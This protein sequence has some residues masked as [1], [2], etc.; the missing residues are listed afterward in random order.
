MVI[1]WHFLLCKHQLWVLCLLLKERE[2]VVG[3]VL[4]WSYNSL[5]LLCHR[6]PRPTGDTNFVGCSMP[7]PHRRRQSLLA[8]T[9]DA[10]NHWVHIETGPTMSKIHL[11]FVGVTCT[12]K[13]HV[14]TTLQAKN[15]KYSPTTCI[16]K[17]K[18]T[19]PLSKTPPSSLKG[20]K[21]VEVVVRRAVG[22]VAVGCRL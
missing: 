7:Q 6:R 14:L 3:H 4:S 5:N 21:K 1:T 16:H 13:N 2:K 10:T 20:G 22:T 19:T 18:I 12:Q 11:P 8:T 9:Y 15:N 17:P